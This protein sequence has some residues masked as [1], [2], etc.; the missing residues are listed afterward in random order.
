MQQ[1]LKDIGSYENVSDAK[2]NR[3]KV[4]RFELLFVEV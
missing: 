2:T 1:V 4:D 3:E